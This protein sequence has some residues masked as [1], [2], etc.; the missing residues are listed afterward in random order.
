MPVGNEDG[1]DHELTES[2][3]KIKLPISPE[4]S[5][6]LAPRKQTR[7]T[8]QKYGTKTSLRMNQLY[9]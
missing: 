9:D 8:K 3:A 2:G 1:F 7:V 5:D 6:L 4:I